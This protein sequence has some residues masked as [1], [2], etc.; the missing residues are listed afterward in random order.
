M[1]KTNKKRNKSDKCVFSYGFPAMN[2][3]DMIS[4]WN[5]VLGWNLQYRKG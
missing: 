4:K 2:F 5:K 1:K 3:N